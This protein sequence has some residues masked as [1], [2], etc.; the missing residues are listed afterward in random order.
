[1]DEVIDFILDKIP[2]GIVVYD[3]KKDVIYSNNSA[4]IFLNRFEPPQETITIIT[5]IF[6]AMKALKL[7]EWFP[8][9]IYITKA[10]NGSPS[11]WT[12]RFFICES[13]KPFVGMLIFEETISNKLDMNKI[14]QCF[15]LTRR[16]TEVLRLVLNGLKNLEIAENLEISEQTV[17]DHLSN[18]YTKLG[19]E[20][21][22]ALIR[23]LISSPGYQIP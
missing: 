11:N 12:F 18:I 1:M 21:R 6:D 8:G 23:S 2:V 16:E 5:R 10:L 4:T 20:N 7:K 3:E 17:K 19:V 9:D 13:P 22:F 15:R 14:R